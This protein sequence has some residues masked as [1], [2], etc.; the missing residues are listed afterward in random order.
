MVLFSNEV[1]RVSGFITHSWTRVQ[2]NTV[3]KTELLSFCDQKLKYQVLSECP[4]HATPRVGCPLCEWDGYV[5]VFWVIDGVLR[6]PTGLLTLFPP[7]LLS[8]LNLR[9]YRRYPPL[10]APEVPLVLPSGLTLRDYQARAANELLKHKRG[11]LAAPTGSGKTAAIGAALLSVCPKPALWVCH[12]RSL[13]RQTQKVLSENLHEVVGYLGEGV[14]D[15]KPVT[16]ALIQTL[17]RR[18]AQLKNYLYQINTLI[19]DECHHAASYTYFK[20]IQSCVNAGYRFGLSATP[21]RNVEGEELW[22]IGGLGPLVVEIPKPALIRDGFLAEPYIGFL[23]APTPPYSAAS[24]YADTGW[25]ETYKHTII[26]NATRNGFIVTAMKLFK[27]C[28]VLVWS[29]EHGKLLQDLASQF[30]LNTVF[31]WGDSPSTQR[32]NAINKLNNQELD[33]VIATDVFKE[34][35]DIP[36]VPTLVNA[37]GQKSKIA[38]LQRIGRALRP[39]PQKPYAL[40]VDFLDK[41][42]GLMEKHAV[43]RMRV[44]QKEFGQVFVARSVQELLFKLT[45]EAQKIVAS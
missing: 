20:I 27:P 3:F 14:T 30:G 45:R 32:M 19:V 2:L 28:L 33:A 23:V 4:K 17:W 41:D 36:T 35:V 40:I 7:S 31:V 5:R 15:V 43:N 29:V 18:Y 37:A 1:M 9:D 26:N 8:R 13:A 21:Y 25:I 6:V 39:N 42:G 38:T 44:L 11:L 16:V 24:Y 34:G 10:K 22:L 12:T